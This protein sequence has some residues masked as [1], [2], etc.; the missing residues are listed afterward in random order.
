MK[1]W[2]SLDN[3]QSLRPIT[4]WGRVKKSE[5]INYKGWQWVHR[6]LIQTTFSSEW[7]GCT[8]PETWPVSFVLWPSSASSH[9]FCEQGHSLDRNWVTFKLT[10][11]QSVHCICKFICI[12]THC[13]LYLHFARI[14]NCICILFNNK[15]CPTTHFLLKLVN[16]KLL[17][18][19]ITLHY[20]ITPRR[21]CTLQSQLSKNQRLKKKSPMSQCQICKLV[22]FIQGTWF[23]LFWRNAWGDKKYLEFNLVLRK[24]V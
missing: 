18:L 3:W 10:S 7:R 9:K 20:S 5:L 8:V 23:Q 15:L 13:K 21:S 14:A 4:L 6:D 19:H 22:V 11:Y 1:K 2:G 17:A 12:C 16:Q 24:N